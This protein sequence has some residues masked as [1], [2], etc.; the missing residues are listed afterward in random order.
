MNKERLKKIRELVAGI[1]EK[2]NSN[3][4]LFG[5]NDTDWFISKKI[6]Q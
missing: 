5:Y 1:L 4:E 2:I 3:L 6:Q